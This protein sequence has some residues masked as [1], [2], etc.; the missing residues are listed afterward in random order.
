MYVRW[1][2]VYSY[3]LYIAPFHDMRTSSL[4]VPVVISTAS[5]Y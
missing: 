4:I 5:Y 2:S 3:C 1:Q